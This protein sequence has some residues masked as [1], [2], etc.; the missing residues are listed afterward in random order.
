MLLL[1]FY[2]AMTLDLFADEY[3][4]GT[5]QLTPKLDLKLEPAP[6]AGLPGRTV[7]L[8]PGFKIKLFSRDVDHGRFMAFDDDEVLHLAN[9]NTHD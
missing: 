7:N 9:M 4:P 3:P 5:I 8:P 2:L 1:L 6:V